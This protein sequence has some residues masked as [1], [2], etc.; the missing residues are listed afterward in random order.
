M[1]NVYFGWWV[2]AGGFATLFFAAG[3]YFYSFPV[4]Y[5]AILTQ[6]QWSRA[7]TAAAF[8]VFCFVLGL[9][10]SFIGAVIQKV[11]AR[12]VM[13]TSSIMSGLSFVLM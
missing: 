6:T 1:E 10:S 3:T 12:K 13:V 4:F 11:G 5:E 2:V 7:E 9:I 8:S